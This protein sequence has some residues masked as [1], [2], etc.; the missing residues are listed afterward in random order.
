MNQLRVRLFRPTARGGVNLVRKDAHGHGNGEVLGR[1]KVELVFPIQ[2]RRRNGRVRQPVE[3]DV[4]QDVVARQ[5]LGLAVEH[6]RDQRLTAGVVVDH[7][8]G[9]ADR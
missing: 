5:A 4:V 3:R 1:E 2:A 6:A 9:Q 8:G 7:P